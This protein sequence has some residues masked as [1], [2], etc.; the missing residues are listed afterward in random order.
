V[1]TSPLVFRRPRAARDGV[2]HAGDAA[3]F[4]DPFAGDGISLALQSGVLAATSLNNVWTRNE[5][6]DTA[7]ARY[8]TTYGRRFTPL[9]RRTAILRRMSRLPRPVQT[10]LLPIF[11]RRRVVEYLVRLTRPH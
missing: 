8:S 10:A 2:L 7:A 11:R 1:T 9:F 5:T 3:G 6:L 4:I